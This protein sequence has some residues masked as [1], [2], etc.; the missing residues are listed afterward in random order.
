[1]VVIMRLSFK[2]CLGPTVG[3]C[4]T[5]LRLINKCVNQLQIVTIYNKIDM[6]PL[7]LGH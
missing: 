2:L 7:H 3:D 6:A 4:P 1:M 5:G